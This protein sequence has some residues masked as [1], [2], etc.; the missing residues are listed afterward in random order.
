MLM[1]LA[2][3]RRDGQP[4]RRVAPRHLGRSRTVWDRVRKYLCSPR[5]HSDPQG[6]AAHDDSLTRVDLI[7]DLM[8]HHSESFI[9]RVE[10]LADECP[11][12]REAIAEAYVDGRA[13]DNGL[14]RFWAL[15][16]RVRLE[17]ETENDGQ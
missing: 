8:F 2:H 9:D 17:F 15:Q 7:E 5:D 1:P 14:E 16:E 12:T 11:G 10:A 13:P 4:Q 6:R 3:P